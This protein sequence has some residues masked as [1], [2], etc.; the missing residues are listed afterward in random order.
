MWCS[1]VHTLSSISV[2]ASDGL[3]RHALFRLPVICLYVSPANVRLCTKA[4]TAFTTKWNW[5]VNDVRSNMKLGCRSNKQNY[6]VEG[7][8]VETKYKFNWC[9][10]HLSFISLAYAD[11]DPSN[12]LHISKIWYPNQS[13]LKQDNVMV[14]SS[15]SK[16]AI[17]V[18]T[19]SINECQSRP[20]VQKVSQV[21]FSIPLYMYGNVLV[22][23]PTIET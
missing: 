21:W 3:L 18:N 20:S 1:Y 12:I 17:W 16:D 15:N 22:Q 23:F 13:F 9:H 6:I 4:C 14:N 11:V 10:I 8:G 7:N 19:L 5:A 2:G